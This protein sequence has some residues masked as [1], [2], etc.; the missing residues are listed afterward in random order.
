MVS[1]AHH[2]QLP[3]V[4]TVKINDTG[5]FNYAGNK[6][7]Y[8][9]YYNE[10]E[11]RLEETYYDEGKVLKKGVIKFK[12]AH[13]SDYV[14][15]PKKLDKKLIV[16][17]M[18]QMSAV[19]ELKLKVGEKQQVLVNKAEGAKITYKS[20]NPKVASVRDGEVKGKSKGD[21]VIKVTV[22]IKG[23]TSVYKVKVSVKN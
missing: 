16:S 2:G 10:K 22:K 7:L 18:E 4:S 3:A 5:K 11:N 13:C 12:I 23:K 6:K 20:N 15:L 19:S 8:V 21:T 9:Y 1:F 14:V 17:L